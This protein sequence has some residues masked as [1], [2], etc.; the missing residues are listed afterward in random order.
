MGNILC[1]QDYEET[2]GRAPTLLDEI[3]L[4]DGNVWMKIVKTDLSKA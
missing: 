1:D 2:R 3:K 4:N